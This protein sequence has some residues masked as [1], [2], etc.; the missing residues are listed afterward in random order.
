MTE[1]F[2]R[3]GRYELRGKLGEG[4]QGTTFDGVDRKTG[5]AVAIKRFQVRGAKSWKDVELAEREASVLEALSHPALPAHVDH[6]EEN[7]ALY[8]VMEKIEGESLARIA[9]RGAALSQSDVIRFLGDAA[10]VL[11]YLHGRSPPVIHRDIN[12]KNVIRRPDGSFAFVDF[13]A[14]RDRLKPEGGSTVVGTF[15][16]MATEQFQGRALPASDVYAVGATAMRLLSGV[17]PDQLPHKGLAIDVAKAL[18]KGFDPRLRRVLER[19]L[20]PDPDKRAGAI[21][22]LLEEPR[23][24]EKKREERPGRSRPAREPWTRERDSRR[25]DRAHEWNEWERHW[26][27][28]E[29][30]FRRWAREFEDGWHGSRHDRRRAA[31]RTRSEWRRARKEFRRRR[32]MRGPRLAF[33]VFGIDVAILAVWFVLSFSV[34][35]LLTLLSVVFGPG[36]RNAARRVR[37]TGRV[38]RESLQRSRRYVLEGPDFGGHEDA[39]EPEES[40]RVRV[41]PGAGERSE[42]FGPP[43]VRVTDDGEVVDTEGTEVEERA[44][45]RP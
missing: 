45:R 33:A 34:P 41:E 4:A 42:P 5:R 30:D 8:L 11:R 10:E 19:M 25:R 22:P 36:L 18:G 21:A 12:P 39:T 31:A 38:T 37:D 29:H 14:V 26:E 13:G 15:G 20:E 32:R 17:E 16:Y 43:R 1:E 23:A 27:D 6:F 44:R 24:E 2:L 35:L 9:S 3:D 40:R 28:W 7:G